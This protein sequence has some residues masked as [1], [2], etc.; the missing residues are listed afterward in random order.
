VSQ[1]KFDALLKKQLTQGKYSKAEIDKAR[2]VAAPVA[3]AL[4]KERCVPLASAG[5]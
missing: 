4:L 1:A 3:Y 2:S 5:V